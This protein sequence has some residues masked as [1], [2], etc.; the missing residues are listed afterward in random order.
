MLIFVIQLYV[1]DCIDMY[2]KL[3]KQTKKKQKKKKKKKKKI[4]INK[5]KQKKCRRS[6]AHKSI[7]DERTNGRMDRSRHAGATKMSLF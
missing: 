2:W 6:C 7:V 1:F 5:K 4:S 3:K